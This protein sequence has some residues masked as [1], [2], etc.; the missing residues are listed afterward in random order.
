ML[1][2]AG[3]ITPEIIPYLPNDQAMADYI[4][5]S[6]ADYLVTAP[7]WPYTLVTNAPDVTHQYQTGYLW[8]QEQGLNNM[9]VYQLP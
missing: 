2:L 6:N 7:G 4:L 9:A 8:T 3:L 1:D 5:Q